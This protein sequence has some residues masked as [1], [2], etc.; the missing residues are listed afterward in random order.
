MAK[1]PTARSQGIGT[2]VRQPTPLPSLSLRT[3][4]D[5]FGAVQ[6]QQ[7]SNLGSALSAIGEYGAEIETREKAVADE[8]AGRLALARFKSDFL[9][10]YK[11]RLTQGHDGLVDD[12]QGIHDRLKGEM[13]AAAPASISQALSVGADEFFLGRMPSIHDDQRTGYVEQARSDLSS[14]LAILQDRYLETTGQDQDD[15]ELEIKLSLER[16]RQAGFIDDVD[17]EFRKIMSESQFVLATNLFSDDPES[18]VRLIDE[19]SE[20]F[21]YV[22]DQKLASL[23]DRAIQRA[24]KLADEQEKKRIAEI[25]A[26]AQIGVG[27]GEV[28]QSQLDSMRDNGDI[29]DS[30]YATLTLRLDKFKKEQAAKQLRSDRVNASL[31]SGAPLD[32][33]D[34]E[35]KK[36]VDEYYGELIESLQFAKMN[37]DEIVN[38]VV[39][40]V[41]NVGIIPPSLSA[42]LRVWSEQNDDPSKV[43]MGADFYA[44][45]LNE[46]NI[47]ASRLPEQTKL[48]YTKVNGLV[49]SGMDVETAVESAH[50]SVFQQGPAEEKRRAFV[51]A[52]S[53]KNTETELRNFV[54]ET[55]G[56][57]FVINLPGVTDPSDLVDDQGKILALQIEYEGL[58][59]GYIVLG[60]DAQE[61]AKLAQGDLKTKWGVTRINGELEFTHLPIELVH[62]QGKENSSEW[63]RKQAEKE[64]KPLVGTAE[65]RIVSDFQTPRRADKSYAVMVKTERGM[66]DQLVNEDGIAVRFVPDYMLT[67]EYVKEEQER[68]KN[69]I[70]ADA[71]R[72]QRAEEQ[73]AVQP[74]NV[75]EKL[76]QPG[77]PVFGFGA[78]Q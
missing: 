7:M 69:L 15:A 40:F 30:Q 71:L 68:R 29:T 74:Q 75:R 2:R 73:K 56:S 8:Q 35:N 17:G 60:A 76:Q 9:T 12:S 48:I 1:V 19:G 16:A 49:S 38:R 37:E 11:Q 53:K 41:S 31:Q 66:W 39:S 61:A 20:Q 28:S 22:D 57:T 27:R 55:F 54:S 6:G 65:W 72:Q 45:L 33:Q 70:E 77:S 67:S 23:R 21:Q 52:T 58:K 32:P 4:P 47:V 62:G 44:R 50:A 63:I 26:D 14:E 46:N 18:L 3:S 5:M 34:P 24:D 64:L 25:Y 10:E 42:N 43:M 36:A 78:G 59:E 13:L 51:I